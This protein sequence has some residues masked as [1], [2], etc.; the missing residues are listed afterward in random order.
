M[1]L[2]VI[3]YD[4]YNCRKIYVIILFIGLWIAIHCNITVKLRIKHEYIWVQIYC[5]ISFD[6]RMFHSYRLSLFPEKDCRFYIICSTHMA[7]RLQ[8]LLSHGTA[9]LYTN[10]LFRWCKYIY[11]MDLVEKMTFYAVD[12]SMDCT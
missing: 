11:V 7:L 10:I 4:S 9:V 1:T 2:I 8:R 5:I 6:S 3:Y 12:I